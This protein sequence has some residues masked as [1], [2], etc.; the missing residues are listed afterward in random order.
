MAAQDGLKSNDG[1]E[2]APSTKIQAPE[3]HQ[4]PNPKFQKNSNFQV[5]SG[6]TSLRESFCGRWRMEECA[7]R[8][9]EASGQNLWRATHYRSRCRGRRRG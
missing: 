7:I 3:K 4:I 1:E 6:I 9:G 5:K 8:Q 2:K